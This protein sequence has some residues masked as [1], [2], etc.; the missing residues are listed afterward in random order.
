M[1]D[2]KKEKFLPGL[3]II[4]MKCTEI[5]LN[6]MKECICKIKNKN[7]NGTGFFCIIPEKKI[8]LLI[9]NNHVINEE[10]INENDKIIVSLRND[11]EMKKITIDENRKIYTSQNMIQ[12]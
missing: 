1:T 3:P 11:K 5:I 10:I 12:Q 9:T 8:N 2:T 7:G 6:Q 4:T